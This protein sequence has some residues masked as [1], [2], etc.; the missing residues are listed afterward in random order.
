ML[1]IFSNLLNRYSSKESNPLYYF[2]RLM[3][4][5]VATIYVYIAISLKVSA[6]L[7]NLLTVI[8]SISVS[9]ILIS[10]LEIPALFYFSIFYFITIDSHDIADGEIAR[11]FGPTS[12]GKYIDIISQSVHNDIAYTTFFFFLYIQI[13]QINYSILLLILFIIIYQFRLKT[14]FLAL[15]QEDMTLVEHNSNTNKGYSFNKRRDMFDFL[16]LQMRHLRYYSIQIMFLSLFFIS[17]LNTTIIFIM[18]I[19]LLSLAVFLKIYLPIVFIIKT[20]FS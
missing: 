10:N 4:L 19:I 12:A 5:I 2:F 20:R 17:V 8:V 18:L 3:N 11:K 14:I 6:N 9:M 1:V 15:L 7:Y 16:V 13:S